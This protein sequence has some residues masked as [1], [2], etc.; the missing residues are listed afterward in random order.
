MRV[1][2]FGIQPGRLPTGTLNAIT[3][4]A[5]VRV[6][7]VTLFE[8]EG[9]LQEGVGPIRTGVTA[10]VPHGGNLFREKVSAGVCTINGFGKATGFEQ[11][12]ERGVIETPIMLTNTLNV[13]RV[14]DGLVAYML[15]ENGD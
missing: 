15:R 4:V 14:A 1:R 13:A 5:G 8:G 11:I 12:R 9:K 6:G 7:H 10:V 2:D 3:D